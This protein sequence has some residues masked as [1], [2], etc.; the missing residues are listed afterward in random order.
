MKKIL[1]VDDQ[2]DNVFILQDRLKRA[3][4]EVIAAYEGETG[5][6]KTIDEKPD[7]ILL[8]IMMNDISGFD[9]CRR[10]V[11]NE[12]TKNIPIILV[13]ALT[14]AEDIKEGFDAGAFDYIK[15]PFNRDEML[16]RINSAL[17]FS[18][19]NNLLLEL[20]KVKT[21]N[22]TV[23]TANHEIKQPLTLINL[24][25]AAIRRELNKEERATDFLLKRVEFIE[26]ATHDIIDILEKLSS[27]KKP[28]FID[29]LNNL[30]MINLQPD[31]EKGSI[32]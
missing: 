10:L 11:A 1:V 15:K 2:P 7:L 24:S 30:K 29:Y 8:D 3:G 18:E 25:T 5:I 4:F 28:V 13:T 22:A 9:V 20:E 6:Q 27:I 17:R 16:A 12:E 14:D 31:D 32:N 19:T 23:I 21:F 26:K